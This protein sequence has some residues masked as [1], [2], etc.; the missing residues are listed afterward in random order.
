MENTVRKRGNKDIVIDEVP[1][2]DTLYASWKQ[3]PDHADTSV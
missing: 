3:G 2:K 1:Y